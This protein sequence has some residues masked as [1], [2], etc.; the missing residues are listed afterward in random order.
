MQHLQ[1]QVEQCEIDWLQRQ[2]RADEL[3]KSAEEL[4]DVNQ[5]LQALNDPRC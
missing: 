1:A 2:Q 3:N 4:K 5:Q